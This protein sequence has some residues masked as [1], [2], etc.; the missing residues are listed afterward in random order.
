MVKVLTC[1]RVEKLSNNKV[2]YEFKEVPDVVGEYTIMVTWDEEGAYT[3]GEQRLM[4]L[5]VVPKE[6]E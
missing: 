3:Y 4:N 2:A 5:D 6:A 1:T